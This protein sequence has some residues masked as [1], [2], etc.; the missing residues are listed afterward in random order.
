[1]LQKVK[2]LVNLRE[3]SNFKPFSVDNEPV[4]SYQN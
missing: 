2:E 4:I 3:I 1:M